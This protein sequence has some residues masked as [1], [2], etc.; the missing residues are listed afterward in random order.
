MVILGVSPLLLL[1]SRGGECADL[2]VERRLIEE[3]ETE[4]PARPPAA[5]AADEPASG[6]PGPRVLFTTFPLRRPTSTTL[7]IGSLNYLF[8]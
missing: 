2:C 6:D 4:P 1:G 8:I 5:A 7:A 3:P